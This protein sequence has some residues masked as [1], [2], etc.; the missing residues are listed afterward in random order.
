MDERSDLY[1]LGCVFYWVL[2]GKRPFVGDNTMQVMAAHIQHRVEPLSVAAPEV[3]ARM[4]DW[5]MSLIELD[6]EDRPR[7]AKEALESFREDEIDA[8]A[9]KSPA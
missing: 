2:T 4:A 6:R 9:L 5:V 3:P 1:S 7:N 8:I